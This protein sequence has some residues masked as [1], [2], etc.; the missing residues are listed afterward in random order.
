MASVAFQPS[1][2]ETEK[3]LNSLSSIVNTYF[4]SKSKFV[5]RS[6]E[7]AGEG[8]IGGG[9]GAPLPVH[10]QQGPG[11]QT[12][13]PRV[14]SAHQLQLRVTAPAGTKNHPVHH[15]DLD[16]EF[17][18]IFCLF[19][20]TPTWPPLECSPRTPVWS[21]WSES[22]R[23][24]PPQCVWPWGRPLWESRSLARRLTAR[25]PWWGR[26]RARCGYPG[27]TPVA[28]CPPWSER[29]GAASG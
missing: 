29:V 25:A 4:H 12:V 5:M 23:G 8:S 10:H 22:Q 9:L 2:C 24:G 3:K 18:L 16:L 26:A 27:P 20:M 28:T 11:W 15:I 21:P 19:N 13:L 17:E 7:E 1:F 14:K 6:P